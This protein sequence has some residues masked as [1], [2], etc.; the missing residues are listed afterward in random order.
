M[1]FLLQRLDALVRSAGTPLGIFLGTLLGILMSMPYNIGIMVILGWLLIPL[2]FLTIVTGD[3]SLTH[4][5]GVGGLQWPDWVI[6]GQRGV[7]LWYM[8]FLFCSGWCAYR[9]T[10]QTGRLKDGVLHALWIAPV[11]LVSAIIP[12]TLT[13]LFLNGYSLS[14]LLFFAGASAQTC[15]LLLLPLA[16]VALIGGLVGTRLVR[17]FSL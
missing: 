10:R 8:L 7:V 5:F 1:R 4:P 15:A 11:V 12:A 3:S 16:G 2:N 14:I 9:A 13:S 17:T 6:W